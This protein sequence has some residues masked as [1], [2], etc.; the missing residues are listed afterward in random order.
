LTAAR[1]ALDTMYG[2]TESAWT[3]ADGRL[4]LAAVI[5][6][7]ATATVRIPDAVIAD[8][9][10]GGQRL[11]VVDGVTAVSADGDD[12]VIEIGSGSYTFVVD[13]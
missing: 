8:V 3:L 5:P 1:A 4:T 6:P 2:R 9:T 10:E 13:R 11:D 12:L 7:N